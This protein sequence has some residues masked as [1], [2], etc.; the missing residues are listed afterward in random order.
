MKG[1]AQVDV[2]N[3]SS[4]TITVSGFGPTI[5]QAFEADQLT[6]EVGQEWLSRGEA[7]LSDIKIGDTITIGLDIPQDNDALFGHIWATNENSTIKLIDHPE[8]YTFP[9]DPF[10]PTANTTINEA[11][12]ATFDD[13]HRINGVSLNEVDPTLFEAGILDAFALDGPQQV[14]LYSY[15]HVDS[16]SDKTAAFS[17]LGANIEKA[18]GLSTIEVLIPTDNEH[19]F[20]G[21]TTLS[22]IKAGDTVVIQLVLSYGE[23]TLSGANVWLVDE[24]GKVITQ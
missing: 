17:S 23:N 7:V 12:L 22:Q 9:K 6:F 2:L 20:D 8:S 5:E 1:F 13:K 21:E 11:D 24:S 18:T 10:V 19:L 16:A 15:A 4:N 14:I 3:T